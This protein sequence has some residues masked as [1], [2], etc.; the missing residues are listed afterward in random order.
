MRLAWFRA[1]PSPVER[2]VWRLWKND[3]TAA[4]VIRDVPSMGRE[5]RITVEGVLYW[6]AL[7]RHGGQLEAMATQHRVDFEHLGW[8]A[9]RAAHRAGATNRAI[10]GGDHL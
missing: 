1:R 8:N 3:R 9:D 5:L 4:A 7:Y 10:R 2:V 6:C